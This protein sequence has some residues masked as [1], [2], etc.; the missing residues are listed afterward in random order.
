MNM[1]K[2]M[3]QVMKTLPEKIAQLYLFEFIYV[4]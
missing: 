3:T 1:C 2:N 4:E